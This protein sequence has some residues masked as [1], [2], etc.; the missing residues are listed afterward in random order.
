L[1][2]FNSWDKAAEAISNSLLTYKVASPDKIKSTVINYFK[3]QCVSGLK[4]REKIL[5]DG[6][7]KTN[8]LT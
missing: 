2:D 7:E 4:L 6:G 5:K 3:K 8:I 1:A